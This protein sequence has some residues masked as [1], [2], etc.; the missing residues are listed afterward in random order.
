M[1]RKARDRAIGIALSFAAVLMV[2]STTFVLAQT[3]HGSGNRLDRNFE[4]NSGGYNRRV[5]AHGYM[6]QSLYTV[7]SSRPL[8]TVSR[9]GQMVYNPHNAFYTHARYRATGYTGYTHTRGHLSPS[10]L[11]QFRYLDQH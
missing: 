7:G 5:P 4:V 9:D 8:Y 6:P 11:R 2:G 10:Y 3:R 1:K